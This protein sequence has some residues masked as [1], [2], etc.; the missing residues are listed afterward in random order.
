MKTQHKILTAL[1]AISVTLLMACAAPN[2]GE[3][4]PASDNSN[5][6]TPVEEKGLPSFALTDLEGKPVN[7]QSLQG[8]KVL[9][10][11]W[12]SWCPPCKA[13]MP[14]LE[15]LYATLDKDKV[16]FVL[17]SLDEDAAAARDFAQANQL[18][19]P[20]YFPAEAT[21]AVFQ[22]MGIPATF[23][24]DEQGNLIKKNTGADNYDTDAYRQM[25]R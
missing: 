19:A 7:L 14:S 4:N 12:A 17:L 3:T 13:E 2:G 1:M 9:V 25:L 15:K 22:T 11:L 20:V 24:F 18:K 8:R 23:I 16:A 10:N 21:P 5:V 6:T